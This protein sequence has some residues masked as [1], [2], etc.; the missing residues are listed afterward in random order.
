MVDAI[1]GAGLVVV[2]VAAGVGTAVY[3]GTA[4]GRRPNTVRRSVVV[5]LVLCVLALLGAGWV[6]FAGAGISLAAF[7]TAMFGNLS[8]TARRLVVS[9]LALVAFSLLGAHWVLDP[10]AVLITIAAVRLLGRGGRGCGVD[11]R[12]REHHLQTPHAV[13]LRKEPVDAVPPQTAP[14]PSLAMYLFDDRVPAAAR[15]K[16]RLISERARAASEYLTQQGRG[17]GIDAI[18]VERIRDD[19]APGAV[20]GYLALPPWS[21]QGTVLA[22]G[23]TGLELLID[24]LDLLEHRLREIQESVALTGGEELLTHGRFLKDRFPDRGEDDLRI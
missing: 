1:T 4:F 24:Q 21:A 11:S 22:D 5:I 12:H 7:V 10:F 20:R 6:A 2:N 14:T 19:Y 23:K 3:A 13:D 16:L 8:K 15:D 9:A 18:E 17:S